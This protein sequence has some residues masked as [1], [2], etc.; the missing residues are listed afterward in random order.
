MTNDSCSPDDIQIIRQIVTGDVNAFEQLMKK[1]QNPVLRIVKKHIPNNHVEDA[2]QDVFISMYQSLP[3][4]RYE[5]GFDHWLSAIAVRTCYRFWRNH[6]KSRE[7]PMSS[8]TEKQRVWLEDALS[9]PSSESFGEK[10]LQEEASEIL[11]WALDRLSPEDRMVLEL[12]HLEGYSVKEAA[13][14]LG[15]SAVNVKVRSFRS[16]NKLRK[17]LRK[18]YQDRRRGT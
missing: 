11:D 16:R 14:L 18:Q 7:I 8:L 15:W 10:G 17:E 12:V 6:Y 2:T 13:R 1:Y 4:F 3:T 5:G 9:D